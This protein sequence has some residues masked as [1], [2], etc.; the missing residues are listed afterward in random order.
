MNIP[1]IPNMYSHHP[2][3][4]TPLPLLVLIILDLELKKS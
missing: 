3:S 2:M 4:L 1:N